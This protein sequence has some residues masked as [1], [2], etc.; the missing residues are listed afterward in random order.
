MSDVLAFLAFAAAQLGDQ[1]LA[2]VVLGTGLSWGVTQ[3][4]KRELG[5]LILLPPCYRTTAIR[6]LAMGAGFIATV[7]IHP[8]RVGAVSG[9]CVAL[10]APYGWALL[11]RLLGWRYPRLRRALSAQRRRRS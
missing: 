8:T 7:A 4:A 9:A 5:V 2:A 1:G 11:V 6:V 10:W 3:V